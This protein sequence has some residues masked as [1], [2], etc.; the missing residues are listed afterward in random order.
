MLWASLLNWGRDDPQGRWDRPCM[1]WGLC[2]HPPYPCFY[3]WEVE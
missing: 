2:P 1:C 3:F